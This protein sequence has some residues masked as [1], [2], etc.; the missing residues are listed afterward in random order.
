MD[1]NLK[2]MQFPFFKILGF[3]ENQLANVKLPI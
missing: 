3:L 1:N 2:E